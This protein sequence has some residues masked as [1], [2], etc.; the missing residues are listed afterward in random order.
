MT[1]PDKGMTCVVVEWMKEKGAHF[2][3]APFE[4]EWQLVEL[5][6]I[7]CVD[8]ILA[9]DSDIFP[10]GANTVYLDTRFGDKSITAFLCTRDLAMDHVVY[11]KK[12]LTKCSA[13]W[14]GVVT[15]SRSF[16][17]SLDVT[18]SRESTTVVLLLC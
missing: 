9:T 2:V 11:E 6:R 14:N 17:P 10:L 13:S 12:Q 8:G 18:I 16:V 5:E 3:C 4:A 1:A 7:G 15:V